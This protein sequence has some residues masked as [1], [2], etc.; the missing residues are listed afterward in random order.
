MVVDVAS[1]TRFDLDPFTGTFHVLD[2]TGNLITNQLLEQ[3]RER[4]HFFFD[5]AGL[6]N[7]IAPHLLTLVALSATPDQLN[8][9]FDHNAR[10]QMVPYAINLA[11]RHRVCA[12]D[13]FSGFT[14]DER[15]PA[16]Y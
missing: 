6:H 5:R 4:F 1:A 11:V 7:H 12:P 16:T 9:A 2:V 3:N 8:Q 13:L 10:N 15:Y 14:N